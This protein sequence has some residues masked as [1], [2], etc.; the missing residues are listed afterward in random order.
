MIKI[1]KVIKN[2]G[3]L[4]DYKPEKIFDACISAGASKGVADKVSKLVTR[5]IQLIESDKLRDI[6]LNK[7][8]ELDKDVA[9]N[10]IKYDLEN[11]HVNSKQLIKLY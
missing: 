9:N 2:D 1:L 3:K 10:W 4:V 6:V 11:A 7:L 8:K 5:E